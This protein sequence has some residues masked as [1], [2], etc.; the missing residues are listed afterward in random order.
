MEPKLDAAYVVFAG[1]PI[2]LHAISPR[3]SRPSQSTLPAAY[4][5][6]QVLPRIM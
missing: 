4:L 5:T 2:A 6:N 1:P 3:Y